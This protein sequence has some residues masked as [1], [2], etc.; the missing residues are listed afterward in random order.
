MQKI[1]HKRDEV[2][3]F[4]SAYMSE[5]RRVLFI[6]TVGFNDA[7]NYFATALNHYCKNIEYKFFLEERSVV[8]QLVLD[9]GA[10]NHD[11]LRDALKGRSVEFV[12]I[13]I[14]AG[15]TATVAGRNA[16]KLGQA[17]LNPNYTDVIID[18]TSMSR[19]VCFSVTKQAVQ[20]AHTHGIDPHILVAE[21]SLAGIDVQT[22]SSD[23]ACYMHGFQEDMDTDS[24]SDALVLWLPQLAEGAS[25]SL[26]RIYSTL[27][28]SEVCP[29]LPFPAA[30]PRRSDQLLSK[31]RVP[32][33]GTWEVSLLDMIYAHESDPLDVCETI[34][35]LHN[36]RN[37]IFKNA[38]SV[39]AR[40]VLSPSGWRI[41]SV[42]MLLAALEL[43][44][45]VMYTESIGYTVT[46]G[47]FPVLNT[48]I[49]DCR[50]HVW[51]PPSRT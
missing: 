19:G 39:P 44:L 16:V 22:M 24:L 46:D 12:P 23:V 48:N 42:G 33:L 21:R 28:P 10:R 37:D 8:P 5:E 49:P 13:T 35:R 38:T 25:P 26:E 36:G 27:K 31:F 45:P 50:W 7:G 40:T 17:W 18:V 30:S 51:L 3:E 11:Y 34:A 20:F 41:G 15:D 14:M 32:L 4:F 29:V 9:A 6:G 47:V 43:N 2:E 1:T